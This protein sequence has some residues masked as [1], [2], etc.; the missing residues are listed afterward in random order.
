MENDY[1]KI[2]KKLCE[3][4]ATFFSAE[5]EI[6]KNI[7]IT[8]KQLEKLAEIKKKAEEQLKENPFFMKV[9]DEEDVG[10]DSE[11]EKGEVLE[12]ERNL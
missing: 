9:G 12:K 10:S 5:M 3:G 6:P 11:P 7:G 2:G 1:E 8:I 4:I